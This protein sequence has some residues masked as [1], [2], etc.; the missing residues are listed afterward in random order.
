MNKRLKFIMMKKHLTADDVSLATG[1]NRYTIDKYVQGKNEMSIKFIRAFLDAFKDVS[2]DWFVSGQGDP[3]EVRTTQAN[4]EKTVK[5]ELGSPCYDHATIAGGIGNGFGDESFTIWNASGRIIV[6]GLPTGPDIPYIQVR[7]NSM[8]N[9]RDPNRSIPDGSWIGIKR[10]RT[11]IIQWGEIYAMMTTNGPIVK[12]VQ[13]SNKNDRIICVSFNE[14]DGYLPF[15]LPKREIIGFM[16]RV[17][18]VVGPVRT[19]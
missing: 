5:T 16:Y 12:V 18:G 14:E 11:D 4:S 2:Y 1:I 17:V 3:F 9:R 7:G 6:P 13:K 10:L 8:L 19:M 15:E